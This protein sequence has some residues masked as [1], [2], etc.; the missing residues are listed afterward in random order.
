LLRAGRDHLLVGIDGR[1]DL[2]PR[3]QVYRPAK[4]AVD[5]GLAELAGPGAGGWRRYRDRVVFLEEAFGQ[6]GQR[7][8]AGDGDGAATAFD[9]LDV[10][11]DE[12]QAD[13]FTERFKGLGLFGRH[14]F[15]GE[16]FT[17][18][19][20]VQGSQHAGVVGGQLEGVLA[21]LGG[22]VDL[23]LVLVD[24]CQGQA[25]RD[26]L[27]VLSLFLVMLEQLDVRPYRVGEGA[28]RVLPT[29]QR[30]VRG[31]L[32]AQVSVG[33]SQVGVGGPFPLPQLL[34][35]LPDALQQHRV[36]RRDLAGLLVGVERQLEV[37]RAKVGRTQ[38][39][40]RVGIFGELGQRAFVLRDGCIPLLLPGGVGRRLHRFLK[41][42][43][44]SC[45]FASL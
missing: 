38:A 43:A 14:S 40:E 31:L 13:R 34:P 6:V 25:F 26:G 42:L 32:L 2:P 15:G 20:I 23:A 27:L 39:R 10:R 36:V 16:L 11:R 45:H 1:I 30:Q 24:V 5:L 33:G 4:Q 22:I 19:E 3:L 35:R 8:L 37:A 44:V 28:G 17:V 18:S 9:A 41:S 21:D 7:L 12:I 29:L